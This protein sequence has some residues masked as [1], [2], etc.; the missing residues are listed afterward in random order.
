MKIMLKRFFILLTLPGL[1]LAVHADTLASKTELHE[2]APSIE[3]IAPPPVLPGL[4][5]DPH[6]AVFG[7]TFYIYP[8][9]DGFKG[10]GST[11]FQ[12]WS[13]HD[14]VDWKNEGVIFDLPRDLT[15]ANGHAWAPAIATKNGKFYFYY[16]ADQNIG[17][18][19]ADSPVG[20]FKDPLGKPLVSK[21]DYKGMQA[22]DPMVFVDDDGSAYLY[23]GQGRCKAVKLN[24]DMISFNQT[25]VRDLTLPG[26]NEGPFVHK[27][28]GK[29]YLSWSEFD[30][31]DPRYSV[32]YATSGSPLGP[33]TKALENPILRQSG[34][35]KGAG[36]HSIVQIPGRDE[37]V[38]AYHRFHIPDGNGF[39]RETCLSRL[40]YGADASILPVD[41]FATVS[42]KNSALV[43]SN[44]TGPTSPTTAAVDSSLPGKPILRAN[45]TTSASDGGYLFVTFKGEQSPLAEQIYFALSK[46]GRQWSALN[47]GAPVL[48]SKLGE[49]GV[50]DPYLLRSHD[51]KAFYLL[52][53]D[54]SINRNPD[55][56]RA[57]RAGSQSIVIWESSDLVHW[58]PPRLVR[59]GAPDA[60]CAW[61]PE[62]VYD[63]GKKEYLTFWASRTGKDHFSKQRIW[64]AW[65]KDFVKFSEP[66]VYI[67]KPWDVIDTDIVCENGTYYRF[68]KDE[69]F[70]SITMEVSANLMGPWQEVPNFSLTKMTGYEGPEC[71]Q[72]KPAI[73]G[74]PATWC[75]ILDQYSK[76]T[77]YHPTVSEDLGGGQFKPG[78][79]FTF[80]FY[81]RHGSVL[82]ISTNEYEQLEKFYNPVK[83]PSDKGRL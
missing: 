1:A 34:V 33:F 82:P 37:W 64:A 65:T 23:W 20:P 61:A 83:S 49:K 24:D 56:Q 31:R 26:Y 39:N 10:W 14:L 47:G 9:T 25:E 67:E 42:L 69:Q 18:A 51:G 72:I 40:R 5:A 30:T 58:L 17:V 46:D 41:V 63:D 77:G 48:I 52:A 13:S 75:L 43:T 2:L 29:Y 11:S 60:G 73:D 50:R 44:D 7:D 71:Y 54:L 8:T 74:K 19:V 76:G 22:I 6:M 12:A 79:N 57:Q 36:H 81:F 68:S 45:L 28:Q 16:C 62:A 21:T 78:E 15:W 70:K 4:N 55:W 59:V 53:T 66:F 3:R 80:P 38:I 32:A 27:R 35:V